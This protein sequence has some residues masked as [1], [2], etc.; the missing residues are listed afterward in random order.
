MLQVTEWSSNPDPAG[1]N[2]VDVYAPG[3]PTINSFHDTAAQATFA[4]K[5]V[6]LVDGMVE[7]LSHWAFRCVMCDAPLPRAVSLSDV[8]RAHRR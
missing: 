2:C 4:A 1:V 5:T 3:H 6:F 7:L 8:P